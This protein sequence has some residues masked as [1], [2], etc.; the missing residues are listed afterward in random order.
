MMLWNN[1]FRKCITGLLIFSLITGG[2]LAA[3]PKQIF[4]DVRKGHWAESV[5]T[6]MSLKGIVK[7]YADGTYGV[8]RSVSRLETITMI[9]RT[10][11]LE[12]EAKNKKIPSTFKNPAAVSEWGK[13]YVAMGV[14]KG[15]ISGND[16]DSFR[17]NDYAKRY[18]VARFMGNAMGQESAASEYFPTGFPNDARYTRRCS[19]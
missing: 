2:A 5:I 12:N 7:G 17:G 6:R 4:S 19:G 8:N 13:G 11:G 9:I 3:N 1:F 18:E 14:I 10:M 15:V 16:L